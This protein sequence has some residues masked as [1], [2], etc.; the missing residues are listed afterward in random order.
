MSF[1]LQYWS[2]V[3]LSFPLGKRPEIFRSGIAV[4]FYDDSHLAQIITSDKY[5]PVLYTLHFSATVYR[6][7]CANRL[8]K[9]YN[10]KKKKNTCFIGYIFGTRHSNWT[11]TE[12]FKISFHKDPQLVK[13]KGWMPSILRVRGAY[14]YVS[15]ILVCCRR[16][17]PEWTWR[18]AEGAE[19]QPAGHPTSRGP[20]Q[21]LQVGDTGTVHREIR[22]YSWA[23]GFLAVGENF[24]LF[25]EEACMCVAL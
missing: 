18:G 24:H 11:S 14:G 1:I 17:R 10:F 16:H 23:Q 22:R 2:L 4:L 15:E 20:G 8:I 19:G 21:H 9:V 3:I 12:Q 5:V 6:V 7:L 13:V 25:P